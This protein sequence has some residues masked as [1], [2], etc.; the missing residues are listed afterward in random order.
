VF[1]PG[2]V[3]LPECKLVLESG[4]ATLVRHRFEI[5]STGAKNRLYE[6]PV[7]G[8]QEKF[9]GERADVIDYDVQ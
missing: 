2:E 9:A 6:L 3:A 8:R 1:N 4:A 5:G 7:F